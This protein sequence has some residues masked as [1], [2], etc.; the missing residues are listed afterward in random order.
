MIILRETRGELIKDVA[1][2]KKY[3]K[4]GNKEILDSLREQFEQVD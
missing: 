4:N 2:V 1:V 3:I